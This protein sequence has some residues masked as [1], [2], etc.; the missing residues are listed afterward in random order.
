MIEIPRAA[1]PARALGL[2]LSLLFALTIGAWGQTPAAA[3]PS[4]ITKIAKYNCTGPKCLEVVLG[5]EVIVTVDGQ[6]ML[7]PRDWTLLLDGR[8]VIDPAE[9]P[10]V[11]DNNRDLVFRLHRTEA[12]KAAWTDILGSPTGTRRVAVALAR[13]DGDQRLT[14]V[15][16][17]AK[18]K[19]TIN[20][21]F[22]VWLAI[23]AAAAAL[24]IGFIL[25]AARDT[26]IIRD[27]LVPMIPVRE[28]QFSLGRFQMAFWFS[29]VLVSFLFLWVLL[30]DYN[31]VTPQALILMGIATATSLGAITA[32]GS[33]SADVTQAVAALK[34]ANFATTADVEKMWADLAKAPNDPVLLSRR[35]AYRAAA[36]GYLSAA[37]DPETRKFNIRGFVA[38]LINDGDSPALHRLQT[39]G[40]T[41]ALGFVFLADLYRNLAMPEF[42]NTL[43]AVMGVSGASYVGFKFPENT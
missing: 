41:L 25:I 22:T 30:W 37:Y 34:A 42:S 8:Q 27:R 17:I 36:D 15:R 6:G 19:L 16:V 20:I 2:A 11:P 10:A 1:V 39:F 13:L 5:D 12:T 32:G 3:P 7:T 31:T 38:D 28:R 35:D 29:L 4:Q 33:N 40:W 21:L 43:L 18:D 23:A 24:A 9:L 14:D 26:G